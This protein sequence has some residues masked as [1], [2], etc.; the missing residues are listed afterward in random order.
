MPKTQKNIIIGLIIVIILSTIIYS[1]IQTQKPATIVSNSN[2]TTNNQTIDQNQAN[3]GFI[4]YKTD[5]Y[6]IS[7]RYPVDTLDKNQIIKKF[8]ETEVQ[9]KQEE[10]RKS[11][12]QNTTKKLPYSY[13]AD[14]V[15]LESSRANTVTY[16]IQKEIFS[17]TQNAMSQV[18]TFTF[19]KTGKINL[20][21]R[22]NALGAN[23]ANFFDLKQDNQIKLL[24]MIE[25]KLLKDKAL[26]GYVNKE[27]I[28]SKFKLNCVDKNNKVVTT[29]IKCI[30]EKGFLLVSFLSNL[31]N[32]AITDAGVTFMFDK[33][34]IAAGAAGIV[35]VDF[36]WDE[37]KPLMNPDFKLN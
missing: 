36:T 2:S 4:N 8:F 11:I 14:F 9:N 31:Q 10:W 29:G 25:D 22:N 15:K 32:Y 35:K 19:D 7:V 26:S 28:E 13:V 3:E 18:K 27:N 6:N 24:K 33:Y 16:I 30:D 12:A 23:L 34:E 37:I 5:D 17:G 21:D 1:N 20:D